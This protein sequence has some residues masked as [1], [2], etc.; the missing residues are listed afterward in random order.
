M[1][2]TTMTFDLGKKKTKME[3]HLRP[4]RI[5]RFQRVARAIPR[6]GDGWDGFA[7]GGKNDEILRVWVNAV[8]DH[9][10]RFGK[11]KDQNGEALAPG[12]NNEIPASCESDP[13]GRGWMGWV[14]K[15]RKK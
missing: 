9:D 7:R 3:R 6:G 14:C 8:D 10:I 5:M 4:E 15:R 1:R 13:Q 11:K 2:W 12:E